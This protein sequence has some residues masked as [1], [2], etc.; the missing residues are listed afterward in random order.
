MSSSPF[1]RGPSAPLWS[2]QP[3][4]DSPVLRSPQSSGSHDSVL[5]SSL[6]I[7]LTM[8]HPCFKPSSRAPATSPSSLDWH[9]WLS[10]LTHQG[11]GSPKNNMNPALK[12]RDGKLNFT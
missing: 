2:P 4:F 3:E 11:T 9:L 10:D 8:S 5:P 12:A 1:T 6:K 7:S